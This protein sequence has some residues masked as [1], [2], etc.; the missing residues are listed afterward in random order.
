[1]SYWIHVLI[2]S[3]EFFLVLC[4]LFS[5]EDRTKLKCLVNQMLLKINWCVFEVKFK[6]KWF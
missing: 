4:R 5:V 3:Q 1:M 6:K 2:I